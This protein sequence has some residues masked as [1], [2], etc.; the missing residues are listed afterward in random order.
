MKSLYCLFIT[1]IFCASLSAQTVVNGT[2]K[3]TEGKP[4]PGAII[5]LPGKKIGTSADTS[6]HFSL[7]KPDTVHLLIADMLYYYAD[8][9]DLN[10]ESPDFVLK[11]KVVELRES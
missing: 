5:Y 7:M 8:T 6:G 4:I 1:L 3:D 2:V 9:I 11:D 10:T